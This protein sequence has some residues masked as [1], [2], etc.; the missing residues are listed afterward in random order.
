LKLANRKPGFFGLMN[1]A[2]E[3][4]E[5]A[6]LEEEMRA[7]EGR[8]RAA[9]TGVGGCQRSLARFGRRRAMEGEARRYADATPK[10]VTVDTD[11]GRRAD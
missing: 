9:K 2:A 10:I 5:L 7:M 3:K 11:C 4:R 8:Q 1:D 6:A